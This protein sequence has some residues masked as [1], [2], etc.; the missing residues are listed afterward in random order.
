MVWYNCNTLS[1]ELQFRW[2]AYYLQSGKIVYCG[3]T[4][5]PIELRL[6]LYMLLLKKNKMKW[7]DVIKE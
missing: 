4:W 7:M 2:M 3:E 5:I 1:E 6:Y